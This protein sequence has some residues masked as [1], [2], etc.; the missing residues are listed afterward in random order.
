MEIPIVRFI[1]NL[2]QDESFIGHSQIGVRKT[3]WIVCFRQKYSRSTQTRSLV[4]RGKSKEYSLFRK[5]IVVQVIHDPSHWK[6]D[7]DSGMF[8]LFHS[9]LLPLYIIQSRKLLQNK[10][11]CGHRNSTDL[12]R[13]VKSFWIGFFQLYKPVEKKFTVAKG[14]VVRFSIVH[15]TTNNR[16]YEIKI[17]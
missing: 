8:K 12:R 10:L 16:I 4:H 11:L 3:G 1:W 15:F 5:T 7:Y 2:S 14:I 17:Q 13:R 9:F 6:V